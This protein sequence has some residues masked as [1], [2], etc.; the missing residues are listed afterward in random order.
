MRYVVKSGIRYFELYAVAV[1]VLRVVFGF[2]ADGWA[3]VDLADAWLTVGAHLPVWF[4][5]WFITWGV[6]AAA[7]SA[8]RRSLRAESVEGDL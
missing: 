1:V 2:I 7:D 8:Q 4:A 6:L 5:A 3:G